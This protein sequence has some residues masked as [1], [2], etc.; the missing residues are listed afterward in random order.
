MSC[1]SKRA[2]LIKYGRIPKGEYRNLIEMIEGCRKEFSTGSIFF[3][4][5]NDPDSKNS[6]DWEPREITYTESDTTDELFLKMY[7]MAE[8]EGMTLIRI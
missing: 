3:L 8:D 6:C 5:G 1:I 2:T 7:S 4:I